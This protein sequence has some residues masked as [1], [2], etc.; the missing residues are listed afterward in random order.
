VHG[1]IYHDNKALTFR[2]WNVQTMY[3]KGKLGNIRHEVVRMNINILELS[4]VRWTGDGE[5]KTQ[6]YTLIYSGG[7]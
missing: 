5:V 7:K 2:T 3:Q 6:E 1:I 4:E